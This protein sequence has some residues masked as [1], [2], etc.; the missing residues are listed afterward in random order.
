MPAKTAVIPPQTRNASFRPESWNEESRTIEVDWG[1]GAA[2]RRFDWWSGEEYDEELD[3]SPSAVDMSRLQSGAAPVLNNH[4]RYA[5]EDQIGV[6]E[7]ADLSGGKGGAVLRLSERDEVSGIVKDIRSGIIRNISV[8]YTVRKYQI[9]REAGKVPVYRAIDWEPY[10][11]SFVPVG[12]DKSARTRSKNPE[13]A[14][15]TCVFEE[16]EMDEQE[17]PASAPDNT[18][19]ADPVPPQA[20]QVDNTARA[21]EITDLAVKHGMADKASEWIRSGKPIGDIRAAVLDALAAKDSAAGGTRNIGHVAAGVDQAE[22]TR[23]AA[24]SW[25]L[26]RAGEK[27]ERDALNGNQFRGMSLLDL[28]RDSLERAG[29]RTRGMLAREIAHRA[30]SHSTSDFPIIF[31]NVMHKT[32]VTA[33]TAVPDVWRTFCKIG[34]LSDF[35]PHYRYRPGSFGN[36]AKVAENGT[37]TYGTLPDA[38]RESIAADTKGKLLNLSRQMIINDDLGAFTDAARAMGRGA[39]RTV[40]I[41]VFALLASNPTMGDTG[42]LF[43]ATAETTPGGHAN[44]NTSGAAPTVAGFD[45]VRQAMGQHL[46]VGGNDFVAATPAIWLGPLAHKG[47]ADVVNDSQYDIDVSNKTSFYPN[48]SRGMFRQVVATPRLSGNIWYAFADPGDEPVIEV[49]FLDGE[50]TPYVEMQ[51][52]FEVDGVTWKIRLDYAVGAIGWRGAYKVTW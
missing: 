4:S 15:E 14:G 13:Q 10:E 33:Y 31:Q 7:T 24:E 51:E 18:R 49:A 41:D 25:V 26:H 46:D 32:L 52:G 37:F 8:G 5:L 23:S 45:A 44:L 39:A 28:A 38:E 50:Q 1:N 42:Q 36:L 30:I 40:E 20:P 17:K 48:K 6:V 2:V 21:A 12:A 47:Q 34:S 3:M 27:I 19:A 43:N 29:V 9:T 35:R 22:K 16:T 11:L